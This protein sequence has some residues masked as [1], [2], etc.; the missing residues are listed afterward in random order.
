MMSKMYRWTATLALLGAIG[1]ATPARAAFALLPGGTIQPLPGETY[2]SS[3]PGAVLVP[4]AVQ[5]L[6]FSPVNNPN[7]TGVL[8]VEAFRETN[9]NLDF[10]F[11]LR[12][13]STPNGVLSTISGIDLS[14]FG[15]SP[16]RFTTAV[17]FATDV[18]TGFVAGTTAPLAATRSVGG[19]AIQFSF[20]SV[21][22]G[23]GLAAGATSAVFFVQTNAQAFNTLGTAQI[24]GSTDTAGN[25]AGSNVA[26]M[27]FE[28][29]I[30]A[31]VPEPSSLALCGIAGLIGLG[32]H[33]ARRARS[34]A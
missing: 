13:T 31:A 34:I 33:R 7:I 21:S 30:T 3:A 8:T 22:T 32:V 2:A 16:N 25:N 28:P 24:N 9:G 29:T 27:M 17:D 23:G 11:Q 18:P 5:S 6:I 10:L 12:N 4:G 19:P 14:A 1:L 26:F 20:G 15:S